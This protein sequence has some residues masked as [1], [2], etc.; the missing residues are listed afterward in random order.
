MSEEDYVD[1][2]YSGEC[3]SDK[4]NELTDSG[5]V[6][7][8]RKNIIYGIIKHYDS[9]GFLTKKQRKVLCTYLVFRGMND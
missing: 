4:L 7:R 2:G 9:K 5:I 1:T 3:F 6:D 8:C